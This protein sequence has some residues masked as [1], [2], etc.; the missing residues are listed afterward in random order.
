MDTIIGLG[1][2]GCRIAKSF[3]HYPQ[4]NTFCIDTDDRGYENF[5]KLAPQPSHEDYENNYS[6]LDLSDCGDHVGFFLAGAG[7][8]SGTV[9]R[10][11]EQLKDNKVW[12]Y[13][14]KSDPTELTERGK[15]RERATFFILQEIARCDLI[16]KIYLIDNRQ[17]AEHLEE[18]SI[19]DYWHRVNETISSTVH[20]MNYF[21][22]SDPVLSTRSEAPT[23]AK[24][25]T[26]GFV[27]IESGE[28]KLFYDLQFPRHR[29]YYYA[30]NED[31]LRADS[32]LLSTI[33]GHM[34]SQTTENCSSQY[35]IY[36]TDYEES[37]C[38]VELFSSFIQEQ[39]LPQD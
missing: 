38:Y 21:K 8:V 13:F 14:I 7:N 32:K 2:G 20:M 34:E 9:L 29:L 5:R 26:L 23:P 18:I 6:G 27:D 24:I 17:V 12:L 1:K 36:G 3:E 30:I 16:E 39:D 35:A 25:Q 10:I 22:H 33:K 4:Y 31:K 19:M 37:Y 11:L 28:E 15:L